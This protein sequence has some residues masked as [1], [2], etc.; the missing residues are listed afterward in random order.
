MTN[1]EQQTYSDLL[2][3]FFE[4]YFKYQE[5]DPSILPNLPP[6][7]I[8]ILSYVVRVM[9]ESNNHVLST[10]GLK[11][12]KILID[13]NSNLLP[14]SYPLLF[15]FE[16]FKLRASH[17]INHLLFEICDS[18]VVSGIPRTIDLLQAVFEGGNIKKANVKYGS[19]MVFLRIAA[20]VARNE[21]FFAEIF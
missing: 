11:I 6:N 14:R 19:V 15:I 16:K 2:L 13:H 1:K 10:N 3:N 21:D 8:S 7:Q 17:Q 5:K 12:L 9:S 4:R 18:I 20:I